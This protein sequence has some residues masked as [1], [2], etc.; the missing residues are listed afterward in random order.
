MLAKG[1]KFTWIV[2]R[3]GL[4][5]AS[6]A[7]LILNA[8]GWDVCATP[9]CVSSELRRDRISVAGSVEWKRVYRRTE[10]GK[11]GCG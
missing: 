3:I 1:I 7:T 9:A 2:Q 5:C 10:R 11:G 8:S 6:L 4:L